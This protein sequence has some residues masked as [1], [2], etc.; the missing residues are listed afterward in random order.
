M[1]KRFTRKATKYHRINP[2]DEYSISLHVML[3]RIDV[4][5]D[6]IRSDVPIHKDKLKTF[7]LYADELFESLPDISYDK[8]L[9]YI[10]TLIKNFQSYESNCVKINNYK[11]NK[12]KFIY[13]LP[14]NIAYGIQDAGKSPK[15]FNAN[16]TIITTPGSYIDPCL[17]SNES[18]NFGFDFILNRNDFK[19]IGIP[20]IYKL[21][22]SLD[23]LKNCNI[24][25]QE[26]N[27][28]KFIDAS[29][30][31]GFEGI[32]GDKAYFK[33]NAYKNDLFNTTIVNRNEGYKLI[34][35]KELGDTL[36]A[37]YGTKF[38]STADVDK[39][40]ICLFTNDALLSLRCQILLLPVLYNVMR[41]RIDKY[42]Y[43]NPVMTAIQTEFINL[44][45]ENIIRNNNDVINS[46]KNVLRRGLF[47]MINGKLVHF[48]ISSKMYTLLNN[49]INEINHYTTLFVKNNVS[50]TCLEHFRKYTCLFQAIS[51]FNGIVLNSCAK[52]LFINYSYKK[53]AFPTSFE[54]FLYEVYNYQSGGGI[55][56]NIMLDYDVSKCDYIDIDSDEEHEPRINTQHAIHKQLSILHPDKSLKELCIINDNINSLLYHYFDFI[57]ESTYHSEFVIYIL[58][59]CDSNNLHVSF[60]EFEK[61][62]KEWNEKQAD[63]SDE[64][65]IWEKTF[66]PSNIDIS[67][68]VDALSKYIST[69]LTHLHTNESNTGANTAYF[70][71]TIKVGGG[72]TRITRKTRNKR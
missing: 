39:N 56:H 29:F 36:Q 59:L 16:I 31:A 45:K 61:Q 55:E 6:A 64:A 70:H 27:N 20:L 44:W 42:F 65:Y 49:M 13:T 38:I 34:L 10:A 11:Q 53:S 48:S 51:I 15:K 63:K 67:Y 32:S 41:D 21:I 28:V 43:Y 46:I 12:D 5:K 2:Y 8:S 24:Q 52:H 35:C 60:L 1:K 68:M 72:K 19:N 62:Y 14:S 23:T 30:N 22:P 17:R 33:G 18:L 4:E 3:N 40:S 54:S 9:Y 37:Y 26:N 25:I 66:Y 7:H 58:E 50:F 47:S 71:K 57:G 69:T